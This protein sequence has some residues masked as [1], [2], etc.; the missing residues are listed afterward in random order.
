LLGVRERASARSQ[1]ADRIVE[2]I[3]GRVGEK[4]LVQ[5]KSGR[6]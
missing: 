6:K 4:L 5:K 3:L 1:A 2:R